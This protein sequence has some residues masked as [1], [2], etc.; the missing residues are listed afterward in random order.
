[1]YILLFFIIG[2]I[3][4]SFTACFTWRRVS[5]LPQRGRSYCFSCLHALR[6]YD[7][8]P[9]VSFFQLHGRCRYCGAKIPWSLPILE[10]IGALTFAMIPLFTED[11][12]KWLWLLGFATLL[13]LLSFQDALTR[14]VSD[15]YQLLFLLFTAIHWLMEWGSTLDNRLLAACVV[16]LPVLVIQRLFK[17]GLGSGDVIYIANL[18]LLHGFPAAIYA[19]F[20]GIMSACV[21][22]LYLLMTKKGHG[23]TPLPL[24]PFLSFGA[25]ATLFL[26]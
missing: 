22:A 26:L 13:L 21:F 5:D 8:I 17:D 25:Y 10:A 11:P 9:L 15:A 19:F 18:G 4:G 7:L 1:M 20:I 6:W 16:T 23:K 2:G 14:T 24:L 3:I 12:L